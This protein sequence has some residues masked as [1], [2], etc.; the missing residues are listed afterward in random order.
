MIESVDDPYQCDAPLTD[1]SMYRRPLPST[2]L[3][4]LTAVMWDG[5]E[6]S[7]T[8]TILQDLAQQAND[9]T[10]DPRA[11]VAAAHRAGS[12]GHRRVR[13]RPVYDPGA[14]RR[15][16][17]GCTPTAHRRTGRAVAATV[18]H[19][20][21]RSG[22]SE[23]DRRAV[24]SVRLHDLRCV[25][26]SRRTAARRQVPRPPRRRSRSGDLQHEADRDHRCRGP[27]QPDVLERRHRAGP[28]H[29]HL[30]DVSRHAERGRSLGEGAAEH[31]AHRC[32]APHGGHAA[33]HAAPH[34]DRRHDHDD[35][36]GPGDDHRQ[37]GRRRQ[38]QGTDPARRSRRA[39]RTSTTASP[40]RSMRSSTSTRRGSTIGLTAQEKADLAA[41]LRAL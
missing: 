35:R 5:R 41:F 4:F 22:R 38:V 10:P 1:C 23:S 37:M 12:A 40:P 16:R 2:N 29:R 8:T 24:R 7:P 6:S 21:Q 3:H 34:L 13:D 39:R 17:L 27:Q 30:H 15:C 9:A 25:G 28:V 36:S 18:L 19:R 11:G 26:D 14:R 33:L 31:R 20:H 32:V